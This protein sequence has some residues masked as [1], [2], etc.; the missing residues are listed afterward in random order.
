M[1]ITSK[2]NLNCIHCYNRND[3]L[4]ELPVSKIIELI[5]FAEKSCVS[6]MV[7]SGGEAVLHSQFVDLVRHL[8]KRPK[9]KMKRVLHSNGFVKYVDIEDLRVFD[10]VHLSFELDETG[11]RVTPQKD[12]I[13]QAL[14]LKEAGIYCYFFA[15]IH[16]KNIHRIEDMVN[17]AN[18]IGV[19]IA[20]NMYVD[21]NDNGQLCMGLEKVKEVTIKLHG[22][23][24]EGKILRYT[25]PLVSIVS[26][27]RSAEFIGIKGGCTAGIAACA[28]KANGDVIPCPFLRVKSGNI[29]ENNMRDIWFNSEVF[30]TLRRRYDYQGQCGE[31]E[32]LS[33]CGGCRARSLKTNGILNGD[34]PACFKNL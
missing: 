33:Y 25:S 3:G 30:K 34:D 17:L 18:D 26:Q 15:T 10:I 19:N 28:V 13:A 4:A 7:F 22:Y 1:E 23:F 6:K 29:F 14:R 31:C 24:T 27:Q 32:Y 11:V 8:S 21:I 5:D 2:C 12:I 9:S 20:F 16:S